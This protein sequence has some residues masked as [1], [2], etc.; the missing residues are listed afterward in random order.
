[1]KE[2]RIPFHAGIGEP[3]N[4]RLPK[5]NNI[6]GLSKRLAGASR[7]QSLGVKELEEIGQDKNPDAGDDLEEGDAHGE[8]DEGD[9]IE[10]QGDE[11]E[12]EGELQ[13]TPSNMQKSGAEPAKMKRRSMDFLDRSPKKNKS[14]VDNVETR[15]R[16][17]KTLPESPKQGS[18]ASKQHPSEGSSERRKRVK[19]PV[20]ERLS[21]AKNTRGA[22]KGK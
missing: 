1:M 20:T 6:P 22:Q 17:K 8:E 9:S 7:F 10:A 15:G 12:E 2:S 19:V 13:K 3:G 14:N 5:K 4:N 16:T 21:T 11:D 18:T